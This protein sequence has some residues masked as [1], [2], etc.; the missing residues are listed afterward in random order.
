MYDEQGHILKGTIY[1][2]GEFISEYTLRY[3]FDEFGRIAE[4]YQTTG[5][6]E[7]YKLVYTYNEDGLLVFVDTVSLEKGKT[8]GRTTYDYQMKK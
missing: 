2:D 6:V 1:S 3:V 7:K 5:G 8:T 4:R